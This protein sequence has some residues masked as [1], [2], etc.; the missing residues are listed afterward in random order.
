MRNVPRIFILA[1]VVSIMGL[2]ASRAEVWHDPLPHQI[3]F[4]TVQPGVKI[5]TLDW[6]GNG[7]PLI[8]IAG[9]GDN[10][11]TSD[12][13]RVSTHLADLNRE[14]LASVAALANDATAADSEVRVRL[15]TLVAEYMQRKRQP[16]RSWYMI[17]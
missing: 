17:T 9:A 2:S 1:A 11:A 3:R 7:R 6:G 5:E 8:L 10:H 12:A 13:N 16:A 4:V 15:R 14:L